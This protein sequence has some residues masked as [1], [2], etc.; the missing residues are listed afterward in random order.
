M[1]HWCFFRSVKEKS[2]FMAHLTLSHCIEKQQPTRSSPSLKKVVTEVVNCLLPSNYG[3]TSR[4]PSPEQNSTLLTNCKAAQQSNIW[5]C[6]NN[7]PTTHSQTC[8]NQRS[9]FI[10]LQDFVAVMAASTGASVVP[11][12]S[13]DK[14]VR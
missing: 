3:K 13:A 8:G 4:L 1:E 12:L 7:S 14:C 11:Q 2:I 5:V 9:F 10:S 6:I